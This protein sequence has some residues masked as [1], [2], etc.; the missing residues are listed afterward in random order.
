VLLYPWEPW[1]TNVDGFNTASKHSQTTKYEV[2]KLNWK[3]Q[4][5]ESRDCLIE[6]VR[7]P[8]THMFT[9]NWELGTSSYPYKLQV[10]G[11]KLQS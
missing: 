9:G 6:K 11:Y 1:I 3:V 4:V 7:E 5:Q 8:T 10:T 2:V